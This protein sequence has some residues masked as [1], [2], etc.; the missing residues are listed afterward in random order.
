M[1]FGGWI[2]AGSDDATRFATRQ[3]APAFRLHFTT[4]IFVGLMA[5]V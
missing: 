3:G 1:M 5:N 2:Q 4:L